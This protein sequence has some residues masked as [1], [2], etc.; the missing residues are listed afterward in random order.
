MV[1]SCSAGA[2]SAHG[3]PGAPAAAASSASAPAAS[4][5]VSPGAP[6]PCRRR[7]RQRAPL[8]H[9]VRM[10]R[11]V[12]YEELGAW[13]A[14]PDTPPAVQ[15]IPAWPDPVQAKPCLGQTLRRPHR[16]QQA[17]GKAARRVHEEGQPGER[18]AP[19]QPRR[20]L[21]A[22]AA[23]RGAA[24]AV[25]AAA[26]VCGGHDDVAAARR[27][28]AARLQ[29]HA[30][31]ALAGVGQ[32]RRQPRGRGIRMQ[33][34]QARAR[35]A[36][37]RPRA[38]RRRVGLRGRRGSGARLQRRARAGLQHARGLGVGQLQRDQHAPGRGVLPRP[39]AR[40]PCV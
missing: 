34:R 23:R 32:P 14:P 3:L 26:P 7:W 21:R 11:R 29:R 33:Q 2:P 38:G 16:L 13:R 8:R 1:T 37:R 25:G 20:S 9:S 39:H 18:A 30:R 10:G 15:R 19:R 22:R 40:L 17:P 24:G 28:R 4:A 36:D 35:R 6:P 27:A 5:L 12:G 31:G